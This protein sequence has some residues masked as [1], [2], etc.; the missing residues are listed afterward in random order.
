MFSKGD[1]ISY[2]LLDGTVQKDGTLA[3]GNLPS[4]TEN[5][6]KMVQKIP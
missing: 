4:Y 2:I 5:Y 3:S 6:K 1:S